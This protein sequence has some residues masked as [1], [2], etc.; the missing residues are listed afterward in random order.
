MLS[1]MITDESSIMQ[2]KEIM[3]IDDI[4][5]SIMVKCR[6]LLNWQ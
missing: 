3:M 1:T 6:F 5:T 2:S 4:R